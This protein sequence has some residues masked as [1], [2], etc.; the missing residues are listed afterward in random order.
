MENNDYTCL[1]GLLRDLPTINEDAQT[2]IEL[3][4][5]DMPPVTEPSVVV[6][7][8]PVEEPGEGDAEAERVLAAQADFAVA[9]E[10]ADLDRMQDIFD[11]VVKMLKHEE[12][13]EGTPE[14]TEE[15]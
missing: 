11:S 15:E 10:A 9:K 7:N 1:D 6:Q 2:E 5:K 4:S 3:T 12:T 13:P 14:G 8:P